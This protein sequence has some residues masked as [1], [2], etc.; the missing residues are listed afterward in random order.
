MKSILL[1]DD[2][3]SFRQLVLPALESTGYAVLQAESGME[4]LQVLQDNNPDLLIID[5]YLPDM[6]GEEWIAERRAEGIN[7]PIVFISG[8]WREPAAYKRL[9]DELGV[10]LLV[11]KPIMPLAFRE[12]V[13]TLLAKNSESPAVQSGNSNTLEIALAALRE[14]YLESLPG[15]TQELAQAFEN[16]KAH[17]ADRKALLEVRGHAHK[18]RGTAGSYG[19]L[20]YAHCAGLIEDTI[21]ALTKDGKEPEANDWSQL[22]DAVRE[23]QSLANDG[24]GSAS[25]SQP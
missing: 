3:E 4:A 6:D 13:A 21:T 22:E 19:I 17:P 23:A 7:T 25:A 9:T 24:D 16:A 20:K 15:K 2:D 12:Q 5:G 10:D 11:N 8:Y 18:L 14:K 1:V